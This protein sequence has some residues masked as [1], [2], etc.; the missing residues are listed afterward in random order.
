TL[1]ISDSVIQGYPQFG[2]RTTG[3]FSTNP[4]VE[5]NNVYF[6]VGTCTNPLGL[7]QMGMGVEG[8]YASIRGTVGPSGSLPQ[9]ANSGT[10]GTTNYYYYVTAHS[11]LRGSGPSALLLAG[12][13][14]TNGSAGNI[15]VKW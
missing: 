15:T 14:K 8:A 3:S 7:G 2:V 5:L 1:H 12:Y 4:A 10:T 9:F 6:E 13:A 11:S